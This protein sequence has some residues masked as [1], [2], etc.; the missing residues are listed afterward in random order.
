MNIFF[1]TNSFVLLIA[2]L[3]ALTT[4]NAIHGLLYFV[5]SIIALAI[6]F[7]LLNA[8][9]AAALEVMVYAGAIMVLF[10][11]VVM[12][13]N[14]KFDDHRGPL[15]IYIG[16]FIITTILV[17]EF[18]FIFAQTTISPTQNKI[19]TVAEVA[20]SLFTNY[21]TSIEIASLILLAGLVGAFHLGKKRNS[22]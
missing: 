18:A 4:R 10:V 13:L 6:N 16:P 20:V 12:L 3:L 1:Y 7:Y 21:S 2:T 17:A 19:I 8:P 22:L 14:I 11:F 5:L 15:K 9:L